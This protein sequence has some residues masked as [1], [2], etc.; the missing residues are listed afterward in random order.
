MD[1]P[2][3]N[4]IV[5]FIFTLNQLLGKTLRV[6][7]VENYK[8]PKDNEDYDDITRKLHSD[9]CAPI[10]Q[11]APTNIKREESRRPVKR[12]RTSESPPNLEK[13]KKELRK[14]EKVI[15]TF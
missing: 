3:L 2:K 12:E 11:I 6:D 15:N 9:G 7:H 14:D 10:P 5:F 1:F 8:A 4:T 13:V